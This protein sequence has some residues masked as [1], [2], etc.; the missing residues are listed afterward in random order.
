M[1]RCVV[2]TCMSWAGLDLGHAILQPRGG[3]RWWVPRTSRWPVREKSVERAR[4]CLVI[5]EVP[6]V[7]R[8]DQDA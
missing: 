3:L 6:A 8:E 7:G 1:W 2:M 4:V 5:E